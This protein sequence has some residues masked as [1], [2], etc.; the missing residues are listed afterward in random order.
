MRTFCESP[1]SPHSTGLP[2]VP[3]YLTVHLISI[4]RDPY[5][6]QTVEALIYKRE[7]LAAALCVCE[8]GNLFGCGMLARPGHLVLRVQMGLLYQSLT[9]HEY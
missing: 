9:L 3:R 6:F 2:A 7:I 1:R 4:S 8:T 5:H